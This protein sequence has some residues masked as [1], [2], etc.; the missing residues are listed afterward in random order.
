MPFNKFLMLFL[1]FCVPSF[2]TST[3]LYYLNSSPLRAKAY[4][5]VYSN[6]FEPPFVIP[7][8][9]GIYNAVIARSDSDEA[10]SIE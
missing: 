9:A 5:G 6:S 10:I 8:K 4:G 2:D 1:P 3:I 7:A